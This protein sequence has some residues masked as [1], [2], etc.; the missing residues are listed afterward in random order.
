MNVATG[1]AIPSE[2]PKNPCPATGMKTIIMTSQARTPKVSPLTTA[3]PGKSFSDPGIDDAPTDGSDD[4]VSNPAGIRRKLQACIAIRDGDDVCNGIK[5]R[6]D[7]EPRFDDHQ[8]PNR[9]TC[10]ETRGQA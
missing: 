3:G 7:P 1:A 10:R 8:R 2:R 5:L 4:E 6:Q 9:S